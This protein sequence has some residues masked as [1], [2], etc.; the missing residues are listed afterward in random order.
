MFG[1]L[2]KVPLR[3]IWAH[4]AQDFTPWLAE[5]IEELGNAVGLELELIQEE[6]SVGSF[7]LDILARDLGPLKML[8]SKTSFL[9]LI[10]IT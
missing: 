1:E 6:A 4:E 10:M 7:S 5:N 3:D 9:K 2:K 8:L